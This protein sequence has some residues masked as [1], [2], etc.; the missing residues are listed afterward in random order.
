ML[1]VLRVGASAGRNTRDYGNEGDL[2]ERNRRDAERQGSHGRRPDSRDAPDAVE[3]GCPVEAVQ[4]K[5]MTGIQE[6]LAFQA[7]GTLEN[8]LKPREPLLLKC[9]Y[10]VEKRHDCRFRKL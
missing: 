10:K 5:D 2:P 1:G 9:G 8:T 3:K 4:F 7:F 6:L